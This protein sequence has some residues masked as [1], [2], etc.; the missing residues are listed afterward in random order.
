M[1][2][3]IDLRGRSLGDVRRLLPRAAQDVSAALAVVRPLCEDVRTRGADAVRDATARFDGVDVDELRVSAERLRSALEALDPGVRSALE[4]AIARTRTVHAAQMP[5]PSRVVEPAPGVQVEERWVAADRVGLYVP[6]GNV[7]YPSSVVMNVVP[8]QVAGVRSLAVTSP[9]QLDFDGQP[10]PSVLAACALLGVDEVYRV[11][12]AQAIAMFA[13]GVEGCAPVDVVTGPGNVYVAA[14]KRYV[15]GEVGIDAE[16]GPTEIA[17]LADDSA[18]PAYVAADLIAQAEHDEHAACILVTNSGD[19]LAAVTTELQRQIPTTRHRDR[20]QAALTGQSA[21]ALVDDVEHGAR[22]VDAW[23]PEH[24]EVLT[25]NA[26]DVAARLR[27]AGAVFVGPW[28]PV[29]LGDYLA[30]SNH[31]LPTGGTARHTGGLSVYTFLRQVH[32]VE[33]T[34][35]GLAGAAAHIDAL[36]GAEDLA[37][38]V[39]A[40]RA[41]IPR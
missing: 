41:R 34:R 38:H 29:S 26:S 1:L 13:Y 10:H 19:M 32:V 36:G 23:S 2:T 9:P 31:V 39:A 24:A 3:T 21:Y 37:A 5:A 22:V 12:G 40:V 33:A 30:G 8:A 20:V 11:G 14:A 17:I 28:S 15:Q 4:Q 6:G 7:A 18:D 27:N 35:D 16:A 25:A